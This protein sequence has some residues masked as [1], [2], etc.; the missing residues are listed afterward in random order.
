MSRAAISAAVWGIY[1]MA[2]GL[3]FLLIP[4]TL[5]SLI[6]LPTT[7]EVWIRVL[8][9]LAAVLGGFFF[10]CARGNVVPFFRVSVAGR[11]AFAT[12]IAALVVLGFSG[13]WLLIFA[14]ADLA[15]GIWTWL[16]LRTTT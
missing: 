14:A 8:G 11:L 1:L 13:P 2:A 4:N 3:G 16:A 12:G 15:G 10:Y 9:L 7:T 6:G 5:L